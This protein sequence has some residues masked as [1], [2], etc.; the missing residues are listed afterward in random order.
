LAMILELFFKLH[1]CEDILLV[2]TSSID[3]DEFVF[4][5]ELVITRV[6]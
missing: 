4:F 5:Y 2:F 3:E 6:M 1:Y